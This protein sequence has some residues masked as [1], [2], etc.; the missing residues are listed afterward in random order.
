M[1]EQTQLAS[2]EK[3]KPSIAK[4]RAL[5]LDVLKDGKEL[6]AMEIAE[7]L[8]IQGHTPYCERNFAAPRLTEMRDEGMVEVVGKKVCAK[9]GRKIAVWKLVTD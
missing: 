3:I 2:Y 9:T 5:I 7:I 1:T 8:F 6:T 4:R